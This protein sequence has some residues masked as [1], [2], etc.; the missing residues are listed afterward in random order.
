VIGEELDVEQLEATLA[1]VVH[2][3]DQ[4]DFGGVADAR[5][6]RLAGEEA[7]DGDAVKTAGETWVV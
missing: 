1:Q 6:H 4:G 7:A 3:M 5:E 2:Q